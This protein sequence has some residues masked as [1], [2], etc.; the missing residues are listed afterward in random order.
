MGRHLNTLYLARE[1][2]TDDNRFLVETTPPSS[3]SGVRAHTPLIPSYPLS[4]ELQF[5]SINSYFK[6]AV[7]HDFIHRQSAVE[8]E[9]A[10]H[11]HFVG[12]C[13]SPV[14]NA[15]I[16]IISGG[17]VVEPFLIARA[18][19]VDMVMYFSTLFL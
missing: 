18:S 6:F 13:K 1:V 17:G 8:F 7:N 14:R 4:N 3:Q 9:L 5:L 15:W 11:G 19:L 10:R 12:R 16:D 2:E